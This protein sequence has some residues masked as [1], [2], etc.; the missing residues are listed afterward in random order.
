MA[1]TQRATVYGR[2]PP[3]A[4]GSRLEE[5]RAKR[6]A[7]RHERNRKPD[8]PDDFVCYESSDDE[9]ETVTE[10]KQFLRTSFNFVDYVRA[11]ETNTREV[12]KINQEYGSR[13]ILTHD[14]FKEYSVS[15]NN[16]NKVFC[17]QWLSDRQVVFGTKCN[18]LMVYDVATQKLD[19]IPSLHGRQL[20][21]GGSVVPEQ[22]C[23]I[24]SVQINPSRTLLSTGARSS[25]EIAI[26]RL[27][28]LDPVCVG[29]TGH[30]DWVFDM[31]WLDDEFLVSGSRDTKMALWRIDSDLAEAPDKADVPT[32]RLIRPVCVKECKSAQKVRALAFNK[33]YKE[34]AALTLNSYIHIWSAESFKQKISRKLP[35]CQEN[36]CLAVQ[37]DGVYA[38]GCRS[39][40]L[41]LDA[42]TLQPIKKI[43][44]RY[45]GCG[46]RSA[47]FQ[48]S[49]LTI[50][51]GLG[52]LMFYDVRAQKYLESSINSNRTVVL[53]ASK[54]YVFPDEEYIDGFQNV[55]Y[56]PAI[57]THCYDASGTRL[58]TAGGPLPA[59]LYGNYAGL[60]Q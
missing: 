10:G 17:S 16:M 42:R 4:S 38:I 14:L 21:P 5:R 53:K 49:V 47:S 40:T 41:L 19:Q 26:Y 34:I 48:G 57:Y 30:R 55:K 43:P 22:Q 20:S 28:T 37:D 9:A 24:H 36:V 31:C 1:E 11:R 12:R 32:H 52:M 60:W 58:F 39:Y 33:A 13:H 8:K 44:S 50:G 25:N 18:K 2:H 35:A 3:C 56:T 46:I 27:P 15:L 23:G 54:G 29:E 59:N 7:L 6:L 45:S 51:T